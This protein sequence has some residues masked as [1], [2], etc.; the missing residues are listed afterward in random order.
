MKSSNLA[1]PME[2]EQPPEE[3]L[4]PRLAREVAAYEQRAARRNPRRW[5]SFDYRAIVIR[6]QGFTLF[7]V[8]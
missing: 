1:V 8:R 3:S 6:D 7:R 2:C 5:V 4:A